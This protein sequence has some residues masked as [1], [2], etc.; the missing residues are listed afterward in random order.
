[1]QIALGKALG[2]R[3]AALRS[4]FQEPRLA[5]GGYR[6][7]PFDRCNGGNDST[8][9]QQRNP[10]LAGQEVAPYAGLVAEPLRPRLDQLFHRRRADRLRHVRRVLSGASRLGEKRGR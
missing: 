6:E 1:M 3:E 10:L 2:S 8:A 7:G 9:A 5:W 4:P